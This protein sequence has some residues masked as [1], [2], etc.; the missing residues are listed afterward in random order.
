MLRAANNTPIKVYGQWLLTLDLSLHKQFRWV[1]TVAEVNFAIF[2]VEFIQHFDLMVDT[3]H[4]RLINA[5]TR[6]S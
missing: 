6:I 1:L 5:I 3:R 4:L 2:K